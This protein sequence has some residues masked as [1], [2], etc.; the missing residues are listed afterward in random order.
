MKK[1]FADLHLRPD[2]KDPEQ[3]SRMARKAADLGY[4]LIAFALPA[5]ITRNELDQLKDACREAGIDFASRVDLKPRTPEELLNGIRNLRR[6]FEIV[7]VACESKNVARQAAK[8]RRVDLLNFPGLDFRR[9]YFDRAE[10]ELASNAAAA[11]EIDA[12]PILTLEGPAR[13]RLLSCLRRDAATAQA[14]HVPIVTSSGTSN[15]MLMRKPLELASLAS[16]FDLKK[17]HA[18]DAVTRNP[19][20]IVKRNREK[21]SSDFVTPGIRVIRR[22]KDC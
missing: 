11:L 2:L 9:R 10:A 22:G 14:Q 5:N 6:R 1:A 17:E 21:L 7:A 13:I 20:N 15:T 16:L 12:N 18:L 3:A 4:H 8:D 19:A